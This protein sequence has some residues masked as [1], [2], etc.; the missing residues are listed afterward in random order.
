MTATH[1]FISPAE[2]LRLEREFLPRWMPGCRWFA[3]KARNVSEF[4][5]TR[6]VTIGDAEVFAIEV[7]YQEGDSETYLVPLAIGD[8]PESESMVAEVAGGFL[9]DGVYSTAF[10][11]ALFELLRHPGSHGEITSESGAGK[12]EFR[13]SNF[14]GGHENPS[15]RLLS[16]EQSNSSIIYGEALFLKLYR[17]LNVGINPDVELTRYLSEEAR[18]P[19]TAAFGGEIHWADHAMALATALVPNQGDAW[20][21]ALNRFALT[22]NSPAAMDE[23]LQ[24]VKLLGRRTGEMHLALAGAKPWSPEPFGLGDRDILNGRVQNL[25]EKTRSLLQAILPSLCSQV[26]PLAEGVLATRFCNPA[27]PGKAM[28]VKIRTHGDYHLGQVLDTGGDFVIIDFEGEPGRPSG[29]RSAKSPPLR[30][31]AG[32]MRS[33]H[34]AAHVGRREQPGIPISRADDWARKSQEAFWQS[35]SAAVA[36]TLIEPGNDRDLLNLFLLEKALY[37]VIYELNH[38]PEWLEIPLCGLGMMAV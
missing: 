32:M 1:F 33:F 15:S 37:E 34:Y 4:R 11:S 22:Q 23:W 3:G 20:T 36:G 13:N 35:W 21:L 16:V 19:H 26:R 27:A 30:D 25:E 10:R 6:Q 8:N 17:R 9:Y 7:N 14:E 24:R 29:E 12:F 31:V 2:K 5:I 18:F 38:R 28:P